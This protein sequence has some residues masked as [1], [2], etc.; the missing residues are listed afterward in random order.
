MAIAIDGKVRMRYDR[1]FLAGRLASV[2]SFS[3]S[4]SAKES[5]LGAASEG[6]LSEF[7]LEDRLGVNEP[8]RKGVVQL[9]LPLRRLSRSSFLSV[10]SFV[11]HSRISC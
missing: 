5:F 9:F 4:Q 1:T 11:S 2:A 8:L 10:S 3:S 7:A 6:T